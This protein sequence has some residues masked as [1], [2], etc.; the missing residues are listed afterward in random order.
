MR[1]LRGSVC[2]VCGE[3]LTSPLFAGRSDALCGL[4]QRAH[5]PFERA[6]A[7]GSYE[8]GLKELIH[9]L[10]FERVRPAAGVLGRMLAEA[11]AKLEPA[12][13]SGTISVV[14]VPLHRRKQ[15]ERGFNHAE[16]IATA[17]LKKLAMPGR[18]GMISD[19][20][21]RR[22]ETA[23]QIGLTSHQRREN[24]RGA[25][26]VTDPT[27]FAGRNILLVDDVLTTG[28]TASEC[29]KVLRRAGASNVWVVTVARTL[30]AGNA[31]AQ[32][33]QEEEN[34]QRQVMVVN[35]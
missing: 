15:A 25:F 14:P 4:C 9:L 7:Y 35:A 21:V 26:A 13:P 17:A 18:F 33:F 3:A 29:A 32:E 20:L 12:L 30:K 8:G 31:W 24:L 5:P 19:V 10:K 16:R 27:R 28:T 6:V 11:I 2:A 1:P 34:E 23:S 22:R